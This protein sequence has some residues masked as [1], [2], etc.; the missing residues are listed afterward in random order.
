MLHDDLFHDLIRGID[1]HFDAGKLNGVEILSGIKKH[2]D[3]K[4]IAYLA[5]NLPTGDG[6]AYIAATYSDE[7]V[8]RY[9]SQGYVN[10]DP[11][12][13]FGM[14]GIL[15]VDWAE[16]PRNKKKIVQLF[17]E[18]KEHGVGSQGLSIPIRG[19]HGETAMFS[20]NVEMKRNDWLEF[21]RSIIRDLQIWAFHFHSRILEQHGVENDEEVELSEREKECLKWASLGKSAWETGE[22]IGVQKRTVDFF[23]EQCR[24]KLHSVST[25]QAV[26]KAIR[27]SLI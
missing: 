22:I 10:I 1:G 12:I 8:N 20:I 21:R 24:V 14:R 16:L 7:W 3:L 9:V 23:L 5:V 27:A 6:G 26:A 2:Y 13:Q 4:N 15:P 19:V 11:V 18:A 25:T 17:A